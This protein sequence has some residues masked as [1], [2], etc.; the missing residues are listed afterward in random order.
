M[1]TI[2]TCWRK[3]YKIAGFIFARLAA[4]FRPAR[5][6]L[7]LLDFLGGCFAEIFRVN[8]IFFADLIL[9]FVSDDF[10]YDFVIAADFGNFCEMHVRVCNTVF[11]IGFR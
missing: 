2:R 6:F 11:F 7:R 1:H 10:N 9:L 5:G 4:D 3:S 8:R